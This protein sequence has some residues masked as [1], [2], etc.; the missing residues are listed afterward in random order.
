MLNGMLASKIAALAGSTLVGADM[1]V[2][3]V[4]A[5]NKPKPFCLGFAKSIT[6]DQINALKLAEPVLLFAKREIAGEIP[7][8]HIPVSDPR[9]AFAKAVHAMS[10]RP[11]A[12]IAESAFVHP[13]AKIGKDVSIGHNTVVGRDV[14]IGDRTRIFANVVVEAN[15][16]IGNDCVI[17]SGTVIGQDGF[18]IV[19]DE[20]GNNFRVPHVG[21]VIIH[22][23]VE[24]GAL[25]TICSGT[26]EPTVVEQYVK[27]DDHVHIAHNVRVGANS[28]L[29]ACAEISGSVVIGPRSWLGP[30]CSIMNN[31]SLGSDVFVGLGSVV[32]KSLPAGAVAAG[33]PARILRIATR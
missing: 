2:S 30:N 9:L 29:T 1:H 28:I 15:V 16:R 7:C 32:T 13:S 4:F 12:S 26:I 19:K 5:L 17:K 25:N 20:D 18:G 21:G 33:S 14:E 27:T 11:A 31:I 6:A 23:G 22:D 3:G 8:T 10:C 24:I